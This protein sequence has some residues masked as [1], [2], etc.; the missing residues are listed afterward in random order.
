MTPS[1]LFTQR[2]S[3]VS[4]YALT[5]EYCY[6]PSL[7]ILVKGRTTASSSSKEE[8]DTKLYNPQQLATKSE[9]DKE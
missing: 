4:K 1:T 7:I 5:H 3:T 6:K 2:G 9:G 8:M